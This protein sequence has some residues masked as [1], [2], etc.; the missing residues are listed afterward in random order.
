MNLIGL[1]PARITPRHWHIFFKD[2]LSSKYNGIV[3]VIVKQLLMDEPDEKSHRMNVIKR[4][5]M[6]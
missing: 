3:F 4:S 6:R 5:T 1:Q 2:C